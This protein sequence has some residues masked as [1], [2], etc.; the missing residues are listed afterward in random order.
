MNDRGTVAC[1]HAL[2]QRINHLFSNNIACFL[3]SEEL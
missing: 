1:K 3:F 2:K